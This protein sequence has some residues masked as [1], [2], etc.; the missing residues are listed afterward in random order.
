MPEGGAQFSSGEVPIRSSASSEQNKQPLT[1][2][3]SSSPDNSLTSQLGT[4]IRSSEKQ[5][6][7]VRTATPDSNLS[8]QLVTRHCS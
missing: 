6:A 2:I 7:I 1:P 4:P 8:G 3:R 5:S